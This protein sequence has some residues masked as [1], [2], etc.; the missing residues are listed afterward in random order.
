MPSLRTSIV[1]AA[2]VAAIPTASLWGQ[3]PD[4]AGFHPRQWGVDFNI[5]NGFVGAGLIHFRSPTQAMVLALSGNVSSSTN[6]G[7]VGGGGNVSRI[8]LSLGGRHY[9]PFAPRLYGYR[10]LGIEG[11]YSH[12]FMGGSFGRTDNAVGGGVF[13]ELGAGWLVTPHLALGAAWQLSA[14]Y[15]HSN[16]T[17]GTDTAT[18][19]GFSVTLGQVQLRGQ[20]YF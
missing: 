16:E 17:T 3:N 4:S 6:T 12:A 1:L 15:V 18:Y 9:R 7:S 2:V 8:N 11:S 20:L 14:D 10:T 19:N 13:G 5:G